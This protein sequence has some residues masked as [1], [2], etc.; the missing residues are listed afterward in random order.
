M[1]VVLKSNFN[2]ESVA[3]R[4][5]SDNLDDMQAFTIAKEW[6]EHNC[7]DCSIYYAVVKPDDYKLWRG[8]ADLV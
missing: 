4:L 8:M 2:D 3:E 7:N 1:K 5:H 6:N